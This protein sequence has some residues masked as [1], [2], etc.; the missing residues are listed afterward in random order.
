M[1]LNLK[2]ARHFKYLESQ[3]YTTL[4]MSNNDFIRATN[5][6]NTFNKWLHL[7]IKID[8]AEYDTIQ[9]VWANYMRSLNE[10]RMIYNKQIFMK[11][12]TYHW[13]TYKFIVTLNKMNFCDEK[14]LW[15][16]SVNPSYIRKF[17]NSQWHSHTTK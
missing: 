13:I 17:E 12:K 14:L 10:W 4:K 8:L 5:H 2:L 1:L 3:G 11:N 15:K 9:L 6:I 16:L 7:L